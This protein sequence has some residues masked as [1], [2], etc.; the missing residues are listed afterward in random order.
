M[1]NIVEF[2]G[3]KPEYPILEENDLVSRERIRLVPEEML[4]PLDRA[5]VSNLRKGKVT[6]RM[7]VADTPFNR[8]CVRVK[9]MYFQMAAYKE[10][11]EFNPDKYQVR[12]VNPDHFLLSESGTQQRVLKFEKGS[13]LENAG[14]L[15]P[16]G[17]LGYVV[18]QGTDKIYNCQRMNPEKAD[19]LVGKVLGRFF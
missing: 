10:G 5:E 7:I 15:S 12:F 16:E 3:Y 18:H 14:L 8:E 1:T 2:R 6:Y 13:E 9:T 11:W 19:S 17:H 4:S